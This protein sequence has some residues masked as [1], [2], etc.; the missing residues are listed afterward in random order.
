MLYASYESIS[1]PV[2]RPSS[3]FS[4][5]IQTIARITRRIATQRN[6]RDGSSTELG[7]KEQTTTRTKEQ[8]R[9]SPSSPICAFTLHSSSQTP[10]H[11]SVLSPSSSSLLPH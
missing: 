9:H 6:Q 2:R 1:Y 10:V 4:H 5:L 7:R 11:P 8:K 3:L